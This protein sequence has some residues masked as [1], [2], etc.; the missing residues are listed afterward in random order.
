VLKLL[1]AML[2]AGVMDVGM[3]HR[4]D[5]GTPQGGVASP[6][7]SNV[8]LNRLDRAWQTRG[9]GESVRFADDLVVMCATRQEA[10][11]AVGLLTDLLADLGLESKA[12]KTR[13][14]HLE[15]GGQGIRVSRL[16]SSLGAGSCTACSSG[17]VPCSMAIGQVDAADTQSDA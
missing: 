5:S 1:R 14:A 6:L 12:S 10:E 13:I 11:Y 7:L 3:V 16:S 17:D 15:E 8:Y 9:V 4:S 2:H